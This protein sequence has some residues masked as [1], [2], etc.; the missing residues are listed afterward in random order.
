[1]EIPSGRE[2]LQALF[3]M[4][5]FK[6]MGPD[7]MTVV[8]YKKYWATVGPKVV[9]TLHDIFR[10]KYIPDAF[11]HTFIALIPKIAHTSRV[12]QL[13]PISLC[14]V[15]NILA[16]RFRGLLKDIMHPNQAAFVP[17]RSIGDNSIINH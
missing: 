7:G 11:N 13:C 15:T 14:N 10:T 4:G 2:I 8:F 3:A 17:N 12:D 1:M 5:P 16:S 6:S 9:E